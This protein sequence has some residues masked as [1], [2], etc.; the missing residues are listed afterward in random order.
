MHILQEEYNVLQYLVILKSA[1]NE[2]RTKILKNFS[3]KYGHIY[4]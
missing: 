3:Q 4:Q 2:V 1:R